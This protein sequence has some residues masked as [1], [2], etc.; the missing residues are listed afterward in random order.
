MSTLIANPIVTALPWAGSKKKLLK[1]YEPLLPEAE[2]FTD[3]FTGSG[4][5]V[6]NLC[7]SNRVANDSNV[8]LI[9]A[10]KQLQFN[11]QSV[12]EHYKELA[13]MFFEAEDPKAWYQ[14]LLKEYAV[15]YKQYSGAW[16]A[17]AL[18]LLTQSN[19]GGIWTTTKWSNGRYATPFGIRKSRKTHSVERL[20]QF[21]DATEDVRWTSR[22]WTE[23]V[24]EG[25]VFADPPYRS[26]YSNPVEYKSGG[27][28]H[29]LL[30]ER[31]KDHGRFAYCATDLGDGWLQDTFAGYDIHEFSYTHTAKRAGV[32]KVTE[33]LVLGK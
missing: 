2:A 29:D 11:R 22:D 14:W 9:N 25:F 8:E 13:D 15:N 30:A 28:D 3:L 4:V 32:D 19:F 33:V 31:L 23:V 18:F 1:K 16:E 24:F 17:A 10:F 12:L 5:V 27:V 7:Y 26:T 20:E 21:A 6:A